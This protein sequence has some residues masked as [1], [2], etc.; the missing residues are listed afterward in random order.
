MIP[1]DLERRVL[2]AA[3]SAA[4]LAAGG[5]EQVTDG[6]I[7]DHGAGLAFFDFGIVIIAAFSRRLV[8]SHGD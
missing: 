1:R 6:G 4:L 3:P 7:F 5:H 2:P 8:V